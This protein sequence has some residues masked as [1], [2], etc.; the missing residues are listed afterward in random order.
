MSKDKT[1]GTV[2]IDWFNKQ[3]D[4]LPNEWWKD[5]KKLTKLFLDW[6]DHVKDEWLKHNQRADF[7]DNECYADY[8][9]GKFKVLQ[10]AYAMAGQGKIWDTDWEKMIAFAKCYNRVSELGDQFSLHDAVEIEVEAEK[11]QKEF[12]I[13]NDGKDDAT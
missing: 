13:L 2:F 8:K 1:T 11:W 7:K 12:D 6:G 10:G 4:G 3:Q 9:M 5:P